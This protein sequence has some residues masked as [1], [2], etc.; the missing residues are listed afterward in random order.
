MSEVISIL[1][2]GLEISLISIS[3]KTVELRE[4]VEITVNLSVKFV[5]LSQETSVENPLTSLNPSPSISQFTLSIWFDRFGVSLAF[6]VMTSPTSISVK[7]S[8]FESTAWTTGVKE[9]TTVVATAV[10][11]APPAPAPGLAVL[12]AACIGRSL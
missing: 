6:S 11:P 8:E 1:A 7:E 3:L 9:E 5:G 12:T 2:T 10:V 4:S